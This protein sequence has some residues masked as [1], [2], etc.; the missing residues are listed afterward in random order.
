MTN[1]PAPLSAPKLVRDP[2]TADEP[3][4]KRLKTEPLNSVR[5][6]SKKLPDKQ[7]RHLQASLRQLKKS[8]DARPFLEPVDPVKLNIPKYFEIITNPMDL[9]TIERKLNQG[10][11]S[12]PQEFIDDFNL[13]VENCVKFNGPE[14]PVSKMG[15][16][17]Q[18]Q[19]EKGIKTL[20][21]A[22]VYPF[23]KFRLIPG[24]P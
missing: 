8:R 7:F 13:M 19:F 15:K 1:P 17:L 11:Y 12:T 3:P 2:P 18:A 16:N 5:D 9:S 23:K 22:E 6:P 4:A 14:N 24:T 20:P 10:R 21:P